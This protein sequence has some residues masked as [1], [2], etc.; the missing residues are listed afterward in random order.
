MISKAF[1]RICTYGFAVFSKLSQFM[2]SQGFAIRKVLQM[3]FAKFQWKSWFSQGWFSH[4]KARLAPAKTLKDELQSGENH[5]KECIGVASASPSF[6]LSRF[7][8]LSYQYVAKDFSTF[9]WVG[10]TQCQLQST[11][12]R[13]SISSHCV[14]S[15]LTHCH[16]LLLCPAPSHVD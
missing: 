16:Q 8:L 6:H 1:S 14:V 12:P 5:Q 11:Y 9:P 7:G 10:C 3:D 4:T 15:T 13:C 2:V